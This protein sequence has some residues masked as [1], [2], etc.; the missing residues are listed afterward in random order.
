MNVYGVSPGNSA[1]RV[2]AGLEHIIQ[3][4]IVLTK[5]RVDFAVKSAALVGQVEPDFR[6]YQKHGSFQNA[7]GALKGFKL[8][9][10]DI[11]LHQLDGYVAI[12]FGPLVDCNNVRF[13]QIFD[14]CAGR[15]DFVE[16]LCR[17][18][19]EC[20]SRRPCYIKISGAFEV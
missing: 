17:G 10:L 13:N 7:N 16:A 20:I 1:T 5:E 18:K 4:K 15:A 12:A 19:K 3:F 2:V 11:E 8:S 6:I 9:G 14:G